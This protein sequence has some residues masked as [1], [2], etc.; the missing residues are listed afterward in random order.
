MNF[1]FQFNHS[2]LSIIALHQNGIRS[3]FEIEQVIRGDSFAEELPGDS[4]GKFIFI[5]TGFTVK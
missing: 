4:S 3:L 2:N 5:V 1:N